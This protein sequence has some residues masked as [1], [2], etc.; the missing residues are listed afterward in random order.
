VHN[1]ERRLFL[2][3]TQLEIWWDWVWY[4]QCMFCRNMVRSCWRMV[5]SRGR[6]QCS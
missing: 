4:H 5:H 2:S 3:F 1:K 6:L